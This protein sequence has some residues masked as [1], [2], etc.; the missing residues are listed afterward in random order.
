M[1]YPRVHENPLLKHYGDAFRY[2]PNHSKQ[3]TVHLGEYCVV[4]WADVL[5]SWKFDD[6]EKLIDIVV[7][8]QWD[9]I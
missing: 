4:F 9:S 3:I 6:D 7:Y 1:G 5:V 2:V 8:K